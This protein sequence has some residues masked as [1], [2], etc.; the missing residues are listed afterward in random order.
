MGNRLAAGRRIAQ[1]SSALLTNG[2]FAGFLSLDIYQGKLKYLCVPFLNCYSCPGAVA[3]CP[4]GSL[5]FFLASAAHSLSY[6][7]LGLLVSFGAAAGRFVCGWLCPFGLIQEVI[8]GLSS[9]KYLLPGPFTRMKYLVLALT[10]ALPVLLAGPGGTGVPYFCQYFCPAG[11]LE[12]G[13]PLGLGR[14]ELRALL[15]PLFAWKAGVLAVF[16][17]AMIFIYRPFCRAFCPLGAFYGLFNPLS[18]WRLEIAAQ[19]CNR[20]RLCEQKCP[21]A[22]PVYR[23]PNSP[24]CVRCLACTK[25]CPTGAISFRAG[26]AASFN[27]LNTDF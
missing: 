16:L 7:V 24:E 1:L 2:Y 8:A 4:A 17:V 25:T 11:T 3:A 13:L 27:S 5:Q 26:G 23:R 9:K 10:V 14:P 12:A 19:N 20:C 21:L 22:I 15:G 6:Y 18:F